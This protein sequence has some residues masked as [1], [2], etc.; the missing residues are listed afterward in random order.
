MPNKQM[1][2]GSIDKMCPLRVRMAAKLQTSTRRVDGLD[3]YVI[4]YH[5]WILGFFKGP[6]SL[7]SGF[8][9]FFFFVGH[10]VAYRKARRFRCIE[11]IIDGKPIRDQ[12]WEIEIRIHN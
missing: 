2:Y 4:L 9:F 5:I 8:F 11:T 3:I 6:T 12:K 1:H 7:L 10:F